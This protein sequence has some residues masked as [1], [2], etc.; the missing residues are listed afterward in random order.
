[1]KNSPH[2]SFKEIAGNKLTKKIVDKVVA[3]PPSTKREKERG[4]PLHRRA[5]A[6]RMLAA[7]VSRQ[8]STWLT[9]PND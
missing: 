4:S 3:P 1:M 8:S 5:E 2:Q 9:S 6:V 7:H